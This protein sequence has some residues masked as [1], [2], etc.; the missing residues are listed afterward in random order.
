MCC[1]FVVMSIVGPRFAIFVWWLFDSARWATTFSSF[2]VF[3]LGFFFLPWTT[4]LF[5]LVFPGGVEGFDWFIVG[6]GVF[7]DLSSYGG[8][9]FRS[10][11]RYRS[12]A[13]GWVR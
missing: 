9:G 4:L 13:S 12:W 10:R 6:L 2:W 8:G 1:L 11:S 5:V 3:L 7:F